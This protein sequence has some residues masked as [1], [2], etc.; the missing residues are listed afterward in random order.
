LHI[1]QEALAKV[2]GELI[3]IGDTAANERA[4]VQQLRPAV[5]LLTAGLTKSVKDLAQQKLGLLD[6]ER[7]I[8]LLLEEAR[9]RLPEPMQQ[10]Q[11]A[12][13]VAEA[14]HTLDAFYVSFEDQ[15]RGTREDIKGRV[16]VYIPYL[17]EAKAGTK[18][19]PI[20]D[21]GCGR[22]ELLEVL[23]DAGLEA[24]G[25]DQNRVM[26]QQCRERDFDVTEAD[27]LA[28]LQGLKANSVGAITGIHIIEH[29]PF[30]K[31]VALFD[32][33]F[34]C[35]KP[36]GIVIFETP[37]P[38]NILVGSCNFYYD[39]THLN[40]LPPE[41]IK[42]VVEARGFAK[43]T[44]LRLHE[45]RLQ[46]AAGSPASEFALSRFTSAQDYA[47]IGVKA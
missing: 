39:P 42:Y 28:Y 31:L 47:V 46:I 5:D 9:R 26:I 13:M 7:R 14:D 17:L 30:R 40:P 43:A 19:A 45:N 23:K 36:G 16:S 27:A 44:L 3:A 22:G 32:A 41:S 29:I 12:A 21:I 38:E 15:F 37:N 4:S 24:K 20:I 35:L 10:D 34:R 2:R 6:Q 18:S 1:H 11:I 33:A 25:I 8:N